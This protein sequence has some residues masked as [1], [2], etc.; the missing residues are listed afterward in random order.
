M[1]LGSRRLR[2]GL[3]DLRATASFGFLIDI[4]RG[5]SHR[6]LRLDLL[7]DLALH[8]AKQLGDVLKSASLQMRNDGVVTLWCEFNGDELTHNRIKIPTNINELPV[9]ISGNPSKIDAL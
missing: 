5:L 2:F 1:G 3:D 6:L 9:P 4:W 7:L 8:V